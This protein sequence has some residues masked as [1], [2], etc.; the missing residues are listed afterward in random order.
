[1]TAMA[2]GG[3]IWRIPTPDSSPQPSKKDSIMEEVKSFLLGVVLIYCV[4]LGS[5]IIALFASL[6][7]NTVFNVNSSLDTP[8]DPQQGFA[9]PN[10]VSFTFTP[11]AIALFI[12][13]PL[14][15][16]TILYILHFKTN[17]L[18]SDKGFYTFI[19]IALVISFITSLLIINELNLH[20]GFSQDTQK[21]IE[22]MQDRYGFNPLQL[23]DV[24]DAMKGQFMYSADPAFP[25]HDVYLKENSGAYYLVDSTGKELPVK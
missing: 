15:M 3:R 21:A 20:P 17:L 10:D 2:T 8:L 11:T 12:L 22:W 13:V 14:T 1:M 4:L 19:C 23:N 6:I 9:L 18:V 5:G 7:I 16:S 25:A 24:Q